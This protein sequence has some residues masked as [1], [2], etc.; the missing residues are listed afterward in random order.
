MDEL[1]PAG[2]G[3]EG[4]DRGC[5]EALALAEP[6]HERT[7]LAG[8]HE[9]ARMVGGHGDERVMPA[10]LVV[11]EPGGFH[12]VAVE[13]LR[14]QVGHHLR[15]RLGGELGAAC[16]EAVAQL[17]PVLDD[18]VEH[19]VDAPAGVPVRVRVLLGDS[20]VRGPAGVADAG[21]AAQVP[22][23][24]RH[25]VAELLEVADRVHAADVAVC[26]ERQPSRVVAAV[27]EP[28]EPL[29]QQVAALARP[30]VSDDPAHETP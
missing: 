30:D 8:A 14:D 13:V 21:G 6:D 29:E 3:H 27:L 18:P 4:G 22:V 16:T 5:D 23:R 25:R 1:H 2:L 15:V 11:G 9:H 20:A 10:Q 26:H 24:A 7:L 12:Q 19:D 17:G 28:L